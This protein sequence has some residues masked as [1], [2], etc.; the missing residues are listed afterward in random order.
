MGEVKVFDLQRRI[1][2]HM[3]SKSWM[4]TPHVSYLYEP[5]ITGFYEEFLLL[6]GEKARA[7]QKLSFNTILLRAVIE[8][9]KSAPALNALIS[10]HHKKGEG[11]LKT[12]D[13]I[14][15]CVPWLLPDG[16]M[17]TPVLLNTESKTLD[18]L[19]ASVS[20]LAAKIGNTNIDELLYQAVFSDT[21]D[22]LRKFHL[23]VFKRI[24]ASQISFNRVKG[25]SGKKKAD[26][27][28]IPEDDRL[29]AKNL[30]SGTVTVSNIGSLYKDQNGCFGLLEIIPPQVFAIGVGAVQ[31]KPGVYVDDDGNKKIGIRKVLPMCLAFDHRAVDFADLVP[32][33]KTLDQIF[34]Q[35]K[36]I[37]TW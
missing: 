26:Y 21:I 25:L 1:V 6:T 23:G 29:L 36:V 24:L 32:F 14:N 17:I 34:L 16:R 4:N 9:L 12:C 10:Y 33:L 8:G 11:T 37:H 30:T 13:N 2:S 22:E 27:Y 3:T 5:D 20:D 19:S 7:N 28:K 31:E 15:I 18:E 35:P